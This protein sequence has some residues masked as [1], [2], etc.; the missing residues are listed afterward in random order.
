MF[1]RPAVN[2]CANFINTFW[3][4]S[5]KVGIK[6]IFTLSKQ[7]FMKRRGV[8]RSVT[9][10]LDLTGTS[11]GSCSINF[12]AKYATCMEIDTQN[13]LCSLGFNICQFWQIHSKCFRNYMQRCWVLLIFW[14]SGLMDLWTQGRWD[15]GLDS[16]LNL[17]YNRHEAKQ[18]GEKTFGKSA[19]NSNFLEDAH[20]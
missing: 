16:E 3:K 4:I 14:D 1:F 6:I 9:I 7:A 2:V 20:H 18:L 8:I 19:K 17:S 13:A 12:V 5:N 15:S 11:S 10:T